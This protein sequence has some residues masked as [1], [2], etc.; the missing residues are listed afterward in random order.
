MLLILLRVPVNASTAEI[1]SDDFDDGNYD[2]WTVTLGSFSCASN[3]LAATDTNSSITFSNAAYY[4]ST[5]STGTYSFD[6][7]TP[8]SLHE[9]AIHFVSDT[10]DDEISSSG[11]TGGW[12]LCVWYNAEEW[13]LLRFEPGEAY[14]DTL[15]ACEYSGR[16]NEWQHVDITVYENGTLRLYVDDSLLIDTISIIMV[17]SQNFFIAMQE[18]GAIDNIVVSDTIDIGEIATTTTTTT[19]DAT[20]STSPSDGVGDLNIILLAGAGVA[21]ILIVI[22]I[23]VKKR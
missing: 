21:I 3:T 7:Y 11:L 14:P 9:P 12:S 17:D 10:V 20:S 2:G 1:W 18:G 13:S 23:V 4:N 6:Y 16:Y 15:G 5:V 22:V 8:P 19:S